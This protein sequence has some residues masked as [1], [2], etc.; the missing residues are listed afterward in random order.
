MATLPAHGSASIGAI[1]R[2]TEMALLAH[3]VC[4]GQPGGDFVI[5][6]I[7]GLESKGVQMISRR[8]GF[9]APETGIFQATRQDY[10]AVHPVLTNDKRGETHA[11]LEG[12]S[13]FLGQ[14]GDR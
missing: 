6:L 4:F 3:A 7:H 8:K 2:S 14:N 5:N 11:D 13:R 1:W 10:V 9:D 12:N